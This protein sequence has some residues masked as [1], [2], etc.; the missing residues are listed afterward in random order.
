MRFNLIQERYPDTIKDGW[1]IA[2]LQAQEN[3]RIEQWVREIADELAAEIDW[4][5]LPVVVVGGKLT[6]SK[7]KVPC[8]KCPKDELTRMHAVQA[9]QRRRLELVRGQ[10][11]WAPGDDG[12]WRKPDDL[13][14][15]F[16]QA[17]AEPIFS[18]R[19][20]RNC[21]NLGGDGSNCIVC[22]SPLYKKIGD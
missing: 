11:L 9:M 2:I 6:L 16:I 3:G 14:L 20:C 7:E 4:T 17:P 19:L 1:V 12:V 10:L 5:L 21:L 22:G 18:S 8:V 15:A 13:L